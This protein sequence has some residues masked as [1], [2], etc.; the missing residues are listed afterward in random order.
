[1]YD[2]MPDVPPMMAMTRGGPVGSVVRV[3]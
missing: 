1:V 2:P 3:A